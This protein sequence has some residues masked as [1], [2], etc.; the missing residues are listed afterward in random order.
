MSDKELK[1]KECASYST[2]KTPCPQQPGVM[3]Y[4]KVC[5]LCG[6][7]DDVKPSDQT[8]EGDKPCQLRD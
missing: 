1:Y 5:T 8:T 4:S 3:V 7:Y 6:C 2:V